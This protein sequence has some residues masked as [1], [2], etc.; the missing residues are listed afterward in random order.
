MKFDNQL[1]IQDDPLSLNRAHIA[2]IASRMRYG[3]IGIIPMETVYVLIALSA[4]HEARERLRKLR[5]D[6]RINQNIRPLT[7][8][9]GS[10][11][12]F[13]QL[14]TALPASAVKL[15]GY[16]FPGPITVIIPKGESTPQEYCNAQGKLLI[17]IPQ[18][19]LTLS[20]AKELQQPISIVRASVYPKDGPQQIQQVP[21]EWRNEIDF[22]WDGGK[23][24]MGKHSTV[25][26]WKQD[27][28]LLRREGA[29]P[30]EELQRLCNNMGYPL[31]F[32]EEEDLTPLKVLFVCTGNIC[33]SPMAE[34]LLQEK[35]NQQAIGKMIVESAGTNP[36]P[37]G[38]YASPAA[39]AV[40]KEI[41]LDLSKHRSQPI[42]PSLLRQADVIL[43]MDDTHLDV[44]KNLLPSDTTKVVEVLTRW[45]KENQEDMGGIP[46]PWGLDISV[47]RNLRDLI[48]KEIDR[49]FPELVKLAEPKRS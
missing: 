38:S 32:G 10:I 11:N 33:R 40:M 49:I 37:V 39:V 8:V 16:L 44:V 17:R 25:I 15:F 24:P 21:E 36:H 2:A 13:L 20:L 4:D 1:I 47:Y 34:Y 28:L 18:H 35:V 41:G 46:D 6:P 5:N 9:V 48:R 23:T 31:T 26:E 27:H 30:T 22:I 45:K 42:T 3:G 19:P 14:V 29:Y 43:T 12:H 7:T